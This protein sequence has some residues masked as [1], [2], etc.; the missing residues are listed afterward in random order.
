MLSK[1]IFAWSMYD[2]AN[3]SFSALIV[4]LF[5]PILITGYLGGNELHVGIAMGV[6][7]LIAA[8]LVPILGGIADATKVK[9]PFLITFTLVTV[10]ATALLAFVNLFWAIIIGLLANLS[11]HASL[12]LYDSYLPEITSKRRRGRVSGIGTSFGYMGTIVSLL[13]MLGVLTLFGWETFVGVQAM[14]VAAALFFLFFSLFLFFM[15][16]DRYPKIM[17]HRR[18]IVHALKEVKSTITGIRKYKNLWTFFIASFLYVDALSTAIVFLFLFG[19]TQLGLGVQDFF[20]LYVG[21]AITAA[22][23][24]LFFGKLADMFSPK[25]SLLIALLTWIVVL[26]ALIINTTYITYAIAGLA[27]GALL[28]GVWTTSRPLLVQI[29]P[30]HKI[31]ELFG[32]QGLTEKLGGVGTILFGFLVVTWSYTVA[33]SVVLVFFLAGVLLLLKVQA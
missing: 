30:K 9:K 12:D 5:F 11:Y 25:K 7:L 29:A 15:L 22:L 14:F 19:S 21:M 13:M 33:L 23:G 26:S 31:A 24:S 17:P 8:V 4:T 18:G 27:G 16:K 20:P 2:F 3:T 1:K 32:F 6:S 10:I 28:G